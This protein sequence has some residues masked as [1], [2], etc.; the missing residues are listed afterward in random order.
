MAG[1]VGLGLAAYTLSARGE[2][3]KEGSNEIEVS[4]SGT[5]YHI[6]IETGGT[7]CKVGIFKRVNGKFSFDI[8]RKYLVD[9]TTPKETVQKMCDY[10]NNQ[11][12][13]VFSSMG[14]AAFGPLCL[15]T[16]SPQYGSVTSTPKVAW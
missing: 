8:V 13:I 12:D 10:I 5:T 11:K 3:P 9:T 15:N 16:N 4:T 14:V 7:G 6:G 2:K 1:V